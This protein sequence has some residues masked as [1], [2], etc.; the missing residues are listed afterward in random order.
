MQSYT[1]IYLSVALGENGPS[2][3]WWQ[4]ATRITTFH[5]AAIDVHECPSPVNERRRRIVTIVQF[6]EILIFGF[7]EYVLLIR[8][9]MLITWIRAQIVK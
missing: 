6:A 1:P 8:G 4:L 9:L 7:L 2:K 5:Q 3:L